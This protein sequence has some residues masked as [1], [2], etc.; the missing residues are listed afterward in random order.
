MYLKMSPFVDKKTQNVT[1]YNFGYTCIHTLLTLIDTPPTLREPSLTPIY[2]PL[3]SYE[4]SL[5]PPQHSIYINLY[6]LNT[7]K[8]CIHIPYMMMYSPLNT[9]LTLLRSISTLPGHTCIVP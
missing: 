4:H 5:D 1:F 7:S 9:P 6:S 8:I 2:S 3:I